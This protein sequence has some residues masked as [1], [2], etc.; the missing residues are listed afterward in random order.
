[1]PIISDCSHVLVGLAK[2]V[3]R[4]QHQCLSISQSID[5][6]G[7]SMTRSF[8]MRK[9]NLKDS[10][11][12]S[13]GLLHDSW[14]SPQLLLTTRQVLLCMV[15]CLAPSAEAILDSARKKVDGRFTIHLNSKYMDPWAPPLSLFLH[16]IN[17]ILSTVSSWSKTWEWDDVRNDDAF[18]TG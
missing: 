17:I 16:L 15:P 2:W 9:W 14:A 18:L 11:V 8:E 10:L 5:S 6:T 13:G 3:I 4:F 12:V 7:I 1:M